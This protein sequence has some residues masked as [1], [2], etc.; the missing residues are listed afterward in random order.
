ML[1]DF[2]SFK[3]KRD[4]LEYMSEVD[5]A[6]NRRA[7]PLAYIL[8]IS[9]V[10][11]FLV[12][13]IWAYFA[14]LDQVTRGMG[15]VIP[16]QRIEELKNPDTSLLNIQSIE[17]KENQEVEIGQVL[18]VLSNEQARSVLEDSLNK[19]IEHEAALVRLEAEYDNEEPVFKPDFIAAHPVIVQDQLSLFNSRREEKETEMRRL[20]AQLEQRRLEVKSVATAK[21]QQEES[22]S[23]AQQRKNIA[24]PL[25]AK[26]TF[27][28]LQ[29]LEL[30]QQVN[31][32]RSEVEKASSQLLSAQKAVN[33]AEEQYNLVRSRFNSQVQEEINKRRSELNSIKQML[34]AG[35][36]RVKRTVLT[37]SK[38][39]T[40]KRILINSGPVQGGQTIMEL[41]PLDDTLMVEAKIIP[42]DIAFITKNQKATVKLTAYDFSIFGGLEAKVE[43][44]GVDTIEDKRG[45]I[46][47]NVKLRTN[48]KFLMYKGDALPI[49]PG[50]QASVDIITGKRT[51]L[52]YLLKPILKAKQNALTEK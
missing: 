36:D 51:V 8:S 42:A 17:V 52:D 2:M 6:L 12:A 47:Y 39:A 43:E 3:E 48:N 45:D 44:I 23:N 13:I 29:F 21:N 26:G 16:S 22:L 38:R 46:F 31:T 18:V 30:E 32:L 34:I 20:T 1:N 49:I 50:M 10:L 24:A 7:H 9:I 4:D 40:V 27:P 41:V 35:Q 19:K 11:F 25:V 37:A 33:E 28:R 5:A 14:P 15:T